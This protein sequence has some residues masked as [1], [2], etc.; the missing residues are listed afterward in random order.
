MSTC[1]LHFTIYW[2]LQLFKRKTKRYGI[3]VCET[4]VHHNIKYYKHL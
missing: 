3:N 4:R 2:H 1:L